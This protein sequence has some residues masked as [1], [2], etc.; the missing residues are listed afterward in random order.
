[1][2]DLIAVAVALA[3]FALTWGLVRFCERLEG[4]R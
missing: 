4:E 3:F 2:Q 1:M